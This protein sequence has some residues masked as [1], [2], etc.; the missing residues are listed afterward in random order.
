MNNEIQIFNNPEFG[1]VRTLT[2]DDVV[3]FCGKDV[4]EALGYKRPKDAVAAHCKGAVKRS[5]LKTSGGM[6]DFTFIT[7]PDVFRLIVSSKL[8][9]A[10]KFEAWVFEEV[11]PS[12]RKNGGYIPVTE[13][14]SPEVIV[15]KALKLAN[16]IIENQK[17]QINEMKPKALFADAVATSSTCILVGDLAKLLKQNGY[18][19]GQKRLFAWLREN[20]YLIKQGSS[21]NMPTQRAMEQGLFE[22]K[23]ST[24]QNPD[25]SVRVTKTTKVTGKGQ[26]YFANLFLGKDLCYE[27]A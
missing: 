14:E 27:V 22:V 2:S 11:L 3:W 23:E 12:I 25:G 8:P 6:Q 19:T 18:D 15:A 20:G 5:P 24:V 16:N 21:Y 26:Q 13:D 17:K 7:E 10:Q 9:T 1:S 4:A